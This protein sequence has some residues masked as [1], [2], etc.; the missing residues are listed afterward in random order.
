M[1]AVIMKKTTKIILGVATSLALIVLNAVLI[2]A[3]YN[4]MLAVPIGMSIGRL[5]ANIA[6]K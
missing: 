1:G 4:I 5:L 3:P 6:M 2:P